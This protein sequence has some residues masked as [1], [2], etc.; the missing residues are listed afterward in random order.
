[1]QRLLGYG[2]LAVAVVLA[3]VSA[4]IGQLSLGATD[5]GIA[6]AGVLARVFAAAAIV[7]AGVGLYFTAKRLLLGRFGSAHRTHVLRN[8]LRLGFG[9]G[10]VIALLGVL[11]EQWVGV[12]VSLGVVGFAV[13]YALQEPLF[14]LI[15]WLYI[16]FERPFTV[17]DR[18]EV[19]DS[20]GDVVEVDLLVTTLWEIEGDLVSS[21]QPSGR[22]VTVPNSLV[23]TEEVL[24]YS[25][26]GL[27]Y[28]WNELTIQVAYETDLEYVREQMVAVADDYLG[29]EMSEQIDRYRD[30]L[31]E[32]PVDLEVAD[33]PTVN[34]VQ[35]E[36]WMEL[37]LRYL[38][39]QK[40]SQAV[41][42]DLHEGILAAFNDAP[43]RVKFPV[44]RSR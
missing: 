42:N 12:L 1:V 25:G 37:R 36:S 32:T 13:T 27:P 11:T 29:D 3:V 38:V 33:Q 18:I 2:A 31:A 4:L 35:R 8:V 14:S 7:A 10:T 15:G 22:S 16:V 17:G 23:L 39:H 6:V 26:S 20:K 24:N 19:A 30:R 40:R 9:A 5:S 44:G 28:V 41:R 34:V 21:H 43:E